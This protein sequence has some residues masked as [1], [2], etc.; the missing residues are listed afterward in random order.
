MSFKW[1]Q[2]N[3]TNPNLLS[4]TNPYPTL[5]ACIIN[6]MCTQSCPTIEDFH[7]LQ[8]GSHTVLPPVSSALD[9]HAPLTT[10]IPSFTILRRGFLKV[11][12][13][14]VWQCLT[15]WITRSSPIQLQM[16]FQQKS[17]I[18]EHEQ[19]DTIH[20]C[21]FSTHFFIFFEPITKWQPQLSLLRM[22]TRIKYNER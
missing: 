15:L 6:Y 18:Q 10:S 9:L 8:L 3:N 16:W 22:Q 14:S 2:S 4:F 11:F 13:I 21:Y 7:D 20:S 19:T 5:S 12:S 17:L 1:Q